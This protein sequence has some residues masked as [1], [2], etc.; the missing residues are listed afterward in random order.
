MFH[1]EINSTISQVDAAI[2]RILKTRKSIAH[3][4]L[5][6]ELYTQLKFPVKVSTQIIFEPEVSMTAF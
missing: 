2:V 1:W 3:N 4:L 6:T 5:V